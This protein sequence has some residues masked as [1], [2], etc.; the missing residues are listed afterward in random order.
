[1]VFSDDHGQVIPP[2][3]PQAAG[4]FFSVS[5]NIQV[6]AGGEGIDIIRYPTGWIERLCIRKVINQPGEFSGHFICIPCLAMLDSLPAFFVL[7][8]E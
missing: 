2:E 7:F 1:M 6:D 5:V 4:A 3:I 8:N